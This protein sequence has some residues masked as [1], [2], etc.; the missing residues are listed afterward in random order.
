[1]TTIFK[2]IYNFYTRNRRGLS[3]NSVSDTG[4]PPQHYCSGSKGPTDIYSQ[5]TSTPTADTSWRVTN[6]HSS[7]G[8]QRIQRRLKRLCLAEA[9]P[10]NSISYSSTLSTPMNRW[11]KNFKHGKGTLS[12]WVKYLFMTFSNINQG[13]GKPVK[14]LRNKRSGITKRGKDQTV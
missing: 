5:W 4:P 8:I 7:K 14:I 6:G 1:M 10:Q 11:L 12:Q 13:P 3:L 2:T 9:S